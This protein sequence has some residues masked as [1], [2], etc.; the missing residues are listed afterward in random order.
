MRRERMN[1]LLSHL[2]LILRLGKKWRSI[3]WSGLDGKG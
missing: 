2:L 1:E 3:L